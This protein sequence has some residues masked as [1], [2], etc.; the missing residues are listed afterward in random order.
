LFDTFTNNTRISQGS[1][2]LGDDNTTGGEFLV[3]GISHTVDM[4]SKSFMTQL[5]LSM[6][7]NS[8]YDPDGKPKM[9][10]D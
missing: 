10:D 6:L 9:L 4:V 3:V 7:G 2:K 5:Q 1:F 8:W